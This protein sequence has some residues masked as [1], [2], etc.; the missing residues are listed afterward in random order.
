[1][2]LPIKQ[3][4]ILAGAVLVVALVAG[5]FW[6]HR[7]LQALRSENTALNLASAEASGLRE[8]ALRLRKAAGDA[9]EIERARQSQAELLRLRGEVS[10]LRE[11]IKIGRQSVRPTE[12]KAAASAESPDADDATAPIQL[13]TATLRATLSPQQTLVTGGWKLPNGKRAIILLESSSTGNPSEASEIT[14]QAKF[15]ELPDDVLDGT[16]LGGMRMKG[17][18]T[19]TQSVLE[20]DHSQRLLEYLQTAQGVS[21]TSLP[22]I[23]TRDGRQAQIKSVELWPFDG[24]DHEVGPS[25][26][27]VPKVSA[28]GE[29]V[30]M[31]VLAQLRVKSN[32]KK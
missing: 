7:K 4:G 1:M 2:N 10:R 3:T 12:E 13:Y 28:D 29:R 24:V 27:I 25:L 14:I 18:E 11:Q 23:T 26:D 21:L 8:E 30:E 16:D 9:G 19:T 20:T 32:P 6:Q 31:T 15:V 5:L 22:K 17:R